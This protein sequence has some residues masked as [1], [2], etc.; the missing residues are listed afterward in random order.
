[1]SHGEA[2]AAP[3]SAGRRAEAGDDDVRTVFLTG[4]TGLVGSHAAAAFRERGWRVRALARPA[5]DVRFLEEL[6]ATVVLGDVTEPATLSGAAEGCEVVVHAAAFLGGSAPWERFRAVNVEGVRHV[7]AEAVRAGCRRFVHVSSVAVYGDPSDLPRPVDEAVPLEAPLGP[8]DHYER[9]KRMAEAVVRRA[10]EGMVS[11]SILR[12]VVVTGERDRHFAP[13]VAALAD[14]RIL[15]T[16]GRG[17]NPLPVV[18]A[19]D[20]AEA[21][22][23]AATREEAHGRVYNVADEGGPTQRELLEEAAP[24]G[25]AFVPLPRGGV[26]ALARAADRI[27]A[28]A[29]DGPSRVWNARRVAFLGRPDPFDAT[30][31]RRELGWRPE[32]GAREGWRRALRRPGSGARP[33]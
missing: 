13:R 24:A 8:R 2:E 12:P 4:A 30:R 19:G 9:S 18:Y 11:W 14:R 1:M 31:L 32:V 26:E 22:R 15:P 16:V 17:D 27:A 23:L 25:T 10:A 28:L 20:V 3:A 33:R 21:C 5:S 29:P 6:G 7:L